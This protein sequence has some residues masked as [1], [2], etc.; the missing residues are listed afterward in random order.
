MAMATDI[1]QKVDQSWF[2]NEEWQ[3]RYEEA[4]EDIKEGRYHDFDNLE[5]LLAYLQNQP[6]S[7]ES[8]SDSQNIRSRTITCE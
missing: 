2:A 6:E 4:K 1:K 7:E 3:T 5:D 8:N